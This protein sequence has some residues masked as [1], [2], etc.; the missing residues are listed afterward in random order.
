MK[1][2]VC[3]FCASAAHAQNLSH[4]ERRVYAEK[5]RFSPGEGGVC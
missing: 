4:E 2:L 5:V 1:S 3:Q